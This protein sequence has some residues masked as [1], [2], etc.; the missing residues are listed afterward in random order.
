MKD[1]TEITGFGGYY[2]LPEACALLKIRY[3]TGGVAV[4]RGA[5][6]SVSSDDTS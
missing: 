5:P 3:E 2:S 1:E 4:R 6:Y